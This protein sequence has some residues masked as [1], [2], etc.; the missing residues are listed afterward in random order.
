[1]TRRCKA[2]ARNPARSIQRR[3]ADARASAL[4]RA[5]SERRR[6][7]RGLVLLHVRVPRDERR[8]AARDQSTAARTG[9]AEDHVRATRT[10]RSTTRGNSGGT[11]QARRASATN[12]KRGP[13]PLEL[14]HCCAARPP[15]EYR[16]ISLH[17]IHHA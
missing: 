15:R 12:G 4:D 14:I 16:G 1:A 17:V 3:T 10:F 7:R 13:P 8:S 5:R 6:R 2:S 9:R 11:P